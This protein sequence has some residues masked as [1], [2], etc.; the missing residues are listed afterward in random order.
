MR[1]V[2]AARLPATGSRV[3]RVVG[4]P[5]SAVVHSWPV[6]TPVGAQALDVVNE[7]VD[8][9]VWSRHGVVAVEEQ[10]SLR[11]DDLL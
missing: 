9:R 10:G 2:G 6:R 3:L 11:T 5:S 4:V 1:P 7:L 8:V